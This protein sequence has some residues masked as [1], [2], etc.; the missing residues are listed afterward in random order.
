MR[1]MRVLA[2]V[3]LV[4]AGTGLA[5]AQDDEQEKIPFEGGAFTITETD[6]FDKILAYD[7]RQIARNY[8]VYF[9]R[10]VDLSGTKVALF[11]VGP[12]GNACGPAAVIAWKDE[13]GLKTDSVG[14]DCG[15]PPAA[16]TADKLY[17]VP[18]LLPG[19]TAPVQAW[20]PQERL[21]V[22][23]EL[24]YIPQPG[25]QWSELETRTPDYVVDAFANEDVYKAAQAL[26]GDALYDVALGL[27]VGSGFERTESG[28]LYG[29]GCVPHAC[30]SADAFMAVDARGQKLYF[31]QQG[32]NP[33]LA[34]WPRL[35]EW[36]DEL[37][38]KM[39]AALEKN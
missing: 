29:N 4:A 20:S 21:T 24:A 14:E 36:P 18:Y 34:A 30:G 10:I 13:A 26:L 33:P 37:R 5:A 17:F 12:G 31:A 35:E 38:R 1:I 11:D 9:N 7:G 39:A 6:D 3:L 8:V 27:T 19:A 28:V 25:T 23:G 22:A 32:E 15:A 2:T 16:A